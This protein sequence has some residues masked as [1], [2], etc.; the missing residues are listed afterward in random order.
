M[1]TF[2]RAGA[3]WPTRAVFSRT[4]RSWPANTAC[5][6]S[7]LLRT[8]PRRSS[9]A[10]RSWSMA[11]T[12][13]SS[14]SRPHPPRQDNTAISQS[15][16]AKNMKKTARRVRLGVIGAAVFLATSAFAY[17]S[18]TYKRDFSAIPKPDIKASHDPVVIAHGAYVVNALA[19][20]SACH[21]N[22]ESTN[23]QELPADP[24]DLRGGYVLHAGPFGV[25][26]PVN[27]TSDGETGIGNLS[28][29]QLARTIRHGVTH[30]GEYAPLMSFAV[31]P[32]SDE[33]SDRRHLL[34]AHVASDQECRPPRTS[35]AFSPKPSPADSILAWRRQSPTSHHRMLRVWRAGTTWQTARPF[36]SGATRRR[37]RQPLS[38]RSG[39]ASRAEPNPSPTHSM[40]AT[41]SSR[42]T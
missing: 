39:F 40:K 11:I 15:T 13:P 32:M 37:I 36:A 24:K 10:R 33:D 28:D 31:G 5:P 14:A 35:G 30:T 19:H 21:G 4:P 9:M 17:V 38:P 22:G 25:F 41:K 12:A 42:R 23:K 3:W 2:Q 16:E 26:Y 34:P 20:C 1:M 29:A 27:L 18:L 6:R 7:W 8:A